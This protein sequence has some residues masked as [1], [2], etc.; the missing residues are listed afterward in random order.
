[1]MNTHFKKNTL[2]AIALT[3]ALVAPA[4]AKIHYV[5]GGQAGADTNAGSRAFP[6]K[7]IAHALTKAAPGDTVSVLPGEYPEHVVI[8]VSGTE[9]A[10][11]TVRSQS[12]R[13]AKVR[14]FKVKGDCI[15]IQ[16]FEIT[17]DGGAGVGVDCGQ[18]HTE[19]NPARTGVRI[20]NNY[21]H[22]IKGTGIYSG[23]HALV[24]DNTIRNV[25]RGMWVNSHTLVENNEVD[26]L[27]PQKE[28]R[29]GKK[30]PYRKTQ[31]AFFAGDRITFRGNYF[32]GAPE[33]LLNKGMGVDFFVTWDAWIIGPSSHILIENNRCFNATHASESEAHK[34]KKSSHITYRN[35]LFVNTVYVGILAKDWTHIT[36]ENN[37]F[38]NCGAYPV[39]F[40]NKRETEGSAV[41]NN[42][43]AYRK[44][45]QRKHGGPDAESAIR[46]NPLDKDPT[47]TVDCSHNMIWGCNNRG[48]GETDFVAEPQF[49]N[50]DKGDFRL[51]AGS[52]GIDA[53]VTIPEV[54]TDMRGVK[55]PQGKAYD[56]GAYEYSP[57][58]D[59]SQ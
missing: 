5:D 51:K 7:T 47:A 36:V 29:E 34:L 53:G 15:S 10:R 28:T 2:M 54:K 35:N 49:V 42:L 20:L 18:A 23:T 25:W 27:I 52:P 24:K 3:L 37:T 8:T 26:T 4:S 50:P 11:I 32:H 21:I 56:V 19:E 44:H 43:I 30:Q 17:T 1:M 59:G 41:R 12:P 55:R 58:K 40:Q 33:E 13:K 38:I 22:D 39:W 48:Y 57:D 16:A 9:K 45:D 31:Y 46:N 14:G 6:F